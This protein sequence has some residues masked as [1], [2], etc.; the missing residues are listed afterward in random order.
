M[1]AANAQNNHYLIHWCNKVHYSDRD[2]KLPSEV[3]VTA[4][5]IHMWKD[6]KIGNVPVGTYSELRYGAYGSQARARG[7]ENG[8]FLIHRKVQLQD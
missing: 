8:P 6:S 1:V 2:I 4:A 5:L 3:S 7:R